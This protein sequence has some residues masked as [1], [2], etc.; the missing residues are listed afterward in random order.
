[1]KREDQ[2]QDQCLCQYLLLWIQGAMGPECQVRGFIGK[3]TD[4]DGSGPLPKVDLSGC[5][6]R[7]VSTGERVGAEKGAAGILNPI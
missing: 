6:A 7:L 5:N 4:S 3:C 2:Y 1:M